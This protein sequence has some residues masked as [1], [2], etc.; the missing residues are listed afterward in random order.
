MQRPKL[1]IKLTWVDYT[2]EIF[3][4]LV[5]LLTCILFAILWI[6]APQIVPIHYNMT[7]VADSYGSKS[8]LISLFVTSIIIYIGMTVLNRY[9]HIFNFPV[10]VTS[11]NA[12]SLYKIA[13]RMLSVVKLLVCIMF[14]Y[15]IYYELKVVLNPSMSAQGSNSEFIIVMGV[16]IFCLFFSMIFSIVKMYKASK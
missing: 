3:S 4:F 7:G 1:K 9:P 5:V 8:S 10:L 16:S 13:K 11:S 6:K 2:V 14:L 12:Y 15:L